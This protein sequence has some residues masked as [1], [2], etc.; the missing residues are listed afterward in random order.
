M[1]FCILFYR[2][3]IFRIE[4]IFRRI[5]VAYKADNEFNL[6]IRIKIA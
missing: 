2:L 5:P 4:N 6:T 3:Q 1:N